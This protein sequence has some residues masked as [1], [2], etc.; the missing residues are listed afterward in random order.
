MRVPVRLALRDG[1]LIL[2]VASLRLAKKERSAL[3]RFCG[4]GVLSTLIAERREPEISL[5]L[6]ETRFSYP[7]VPLLGRTHIR[8]AAPGRPAA[9]LLFA[10]PKRA[11]DPMAD[12]FGMTARILRAGPA[13]RRQ[14]DHWKAAIERAAGRSP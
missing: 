3:V 8:I 9:A 2:A 14:R 10:D 1:S 4:E 6:G 11:G 12:P 5:P 7:S 13:A